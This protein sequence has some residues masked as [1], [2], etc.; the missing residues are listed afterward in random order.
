MWKG[1]TA[2]MVGLIGAVIV[3]SQVFA[4][5][6]SSLKMVEVKLTPVT[7]E[8]GYLGDTTSTPDGG[9]LA[10]AP[11]NVIDG[12]GQHL[13]K[14]SREGKEIWRTDLGDVWIQLISNTSDGGYILA[15]N[16]TDR[17]QLEDIELVKM[18]QDGK[19]L[20]RKSLKGSGHDYFTSIIPLASG[21]YLATGASTSSD[22]D[23]K[24]IRP[25]VNQNLE[26]GILFRFDQ[27]GKLVWKTGKQVLK[28]GT[29]FYNG[30]ALSDGTYLVSTAFLAKKMTGSLIRFD[31]NGDVMSESK[32]TVELPAAFATT[33]GGY[34]QLVT[35]RDNHTTLIAKH[36]NTGK[37]QWTV[38]WAQSDNVCWLRMKE[39][40]DHSILL[41]GFKESLEANVYPIWMHFTMDGKKISETTIES[42]MNEIIFDFAIDKNDTPTFLLRKATPGLPLMI[43]TG[44]ELLTYNEINR[45]SITMKVGS[46][47]RLAVKQLPSTIADAAVKWTVGNSKVVTVSP[48]GEVQA[49]DTGKTTVTATTLDGNQ[50]A[51]IALTVKE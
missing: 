2:S 18:D 32:P 1:R 17:N 36:T 23:Y 24:S 46:Q 42:S 8:N 11:R 45:N 31:A 13:L 30:T 19:I 7:L 25:A 9:M 43:E 3:S 50:S 21:G 39:L 47:K 51:T 40:S 38:K 5:S 35:T 33:D 27:N 10:T 12:E 44:Q 37:T 41:G 49:K 4:A 29:R 28:Q 22:G 26:M 48:N 20:W 14:I 34:V 6:G 15:N 16:K